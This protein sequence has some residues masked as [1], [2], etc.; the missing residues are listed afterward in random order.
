MY[1]LSTPHF[2]P[3]QL[4]RLF[5]SVASVVAN[6][7]VF[8]LDESDRRYRI[9][10]FNNYQWVLGEGSSDSKFC[11]SFQSGYSLKKGTF[12][13]TYINFQAEQIKPIDMETF[14]WGLAEVGAFMWPFFNDID[15][16]PL[17]GNHFFL[18]GAAPRKKYHA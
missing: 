8:V 5:S 10:L 4:E 11:M 3:W 17:E 2:N 12:K 6:D 16:I 14:M 18:V 13:R 1:G 9:F 15:W 7:G